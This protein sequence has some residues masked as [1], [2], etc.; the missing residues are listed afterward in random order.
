MFCRTC[1]RSDVSTDLCKVCADQFLAQGAV[2]YSEEDADAPLLRKRMAHLR[3]E[4]RE[5]SVAL[6]DVDALPAFA[7]E[8]LSGRYDQIDGELD[9][10]ER[11]LYE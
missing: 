11:F 10:I 1:G 9:E 3:E 4:Q 2:A 6:R 7:V 5:I 8:W